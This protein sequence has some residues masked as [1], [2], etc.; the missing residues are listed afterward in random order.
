MSQKLSSAAV[1]IGALRVK[2]SRKGVFTDRSKAM[3]LLRIILCPWARQLPDKQSEQV[4]LFV[5]L[6][7]RVFLSVHCSLLV[8]CWERVD[9]LALLCVMF[10]YVFVTF[11]C[12]VLGQLWCLDVSMPDLNLHS[13]FYY[14]QGQFQNEGFSIKSSPF[15]AFCNTFDLH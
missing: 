14:W 10:Y 5:Y 9:H 11:P 12:G 7:C 15:G 6:V 4:W 2:T 3:L 1:V 8:T 13:Y